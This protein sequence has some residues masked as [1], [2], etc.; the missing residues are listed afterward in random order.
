MFAGCTVLQNHCVFPFLHDDQEFA[1]CT[2]LQNENLN[3][4]TYC[5]IDLAGKKAWGVCN[6]ACLDDYGG[7]YFM[8]IK[9]I[10]LD[11]FRFMLF[12]GDFLGLV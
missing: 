9:K 2:K 12:F 3:N 10:T 7:N 5:Q 6:D 4:E 11:F 1:K 8:F